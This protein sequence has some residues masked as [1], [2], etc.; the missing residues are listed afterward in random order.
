MLL[1][2]V[3]GDFRWRIRFAFVPDDW[4]QV[5]DEGRE[6]DVQRHVIL[7]H[8]HASEVRL[9]GETMN[10]QTV[11][12]FGDTSLDVIAQYVPVCS[13]VPMQTTDVVVG[14]EDDA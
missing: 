13:I 3:T 6:R 8:K 2:A 5:P 1:V 14:G 10:A 7:M 4:E 12:A 9:Y 11:Y